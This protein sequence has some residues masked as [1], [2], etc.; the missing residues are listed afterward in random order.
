MQVS[1]YMEPTGKCRLAAIG[2]GGNLPTAF[3]SPASALAG[4]LAAL[5]RAGLEIRAVSRFF[6]TPAYPPG[7]GPDFVN[8]AALL[9]TDLA[10]E[11]LLRRLHEVEAEFGRVRERRWAARTVDIDL[12]FMDD[13]VLPDEATYDRWRKLDPERQTQEAPDCLILP[14]PRM[15]E[16]GFVLIPLAEIAPKWRH[17]AIGRTVAEMVKALPA[18]DKDAISPL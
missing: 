15:H 14:H 3:G 10:P 18:A 2:L 11:E 1:Q 16:R 9:L 17:P 12:L 5:G 7:S 6:R 8:A 13:M 4:A